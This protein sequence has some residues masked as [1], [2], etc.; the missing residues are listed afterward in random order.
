MK[1]VGMV[2]GGFVV[3]LALGFVL[4]ATGLVQKDFFGTWN[5]NID[6]KIFE[7]GKSHIQG[8]I[9]TIGDYKLQYDTAE[10]DAHRRAFREAALREYNAFKRKD[11]LPQHLKDFV[12]GL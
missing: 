3:V 5:A 6:R 4:T 2:L 8:T 10:N 9:Q 11:R 1:E 12:N 7:E